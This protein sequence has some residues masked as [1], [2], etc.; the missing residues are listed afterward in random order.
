MLFPFLYNFFP[1]LFTFFLCLVHILD[2]LPLFISS[3]NLP[4]TVSFLSFTFTH[5]LCASVC[6][7]SSLYVRRSKV[8]IIVGIKTRDTLAVKGEKLS[9]Q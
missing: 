2:L 4:A 8:E 3:L 6:F 7:I 9:R 5:S 1:L